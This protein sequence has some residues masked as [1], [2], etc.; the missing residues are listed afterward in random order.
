MKYM[1]ITGVYK[2]AKENPRK[3]YCILNSVGWWKARL[4]IP[5]TTTPFINPLISAIFRTDK[6]PI[7]SPE[8]LIHCML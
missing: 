7:N 1:E 6:D 5:H 2:Q 3:Q 8:Y 4:E